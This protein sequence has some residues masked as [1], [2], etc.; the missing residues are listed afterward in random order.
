VPVIAREGPGG[1]Y[2]LPDNYRFEPLPLNGREAFLLLLAI[3]S[4]ESLSALPYHDELASLVVKLRAGLPAEEMAGAEGLLQA[5]DVSGPLRSQRAPFLEPILLAMHEKRWLRI[6]YRSSERVAVQ[7]ILPELVSTQDGLWYCRAFAAEHAGQRTFRVDRIQ[8]I[9]QPSEGFIPPPAVTGLPYEHESHP[10][11]LARLTSRGASRAE[12]E[13]SIGPKL[14]RLPDGSA[15]LGF[16]CPPDEIE[17]YA[18]FFAAL[19][20]DAEVL[21]PV[22]LRARLAQMGQKMVEM[23]T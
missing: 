19:G 7:H 16:R 20:E 15:E 6:T 21:A 13:R 23:Y 18:R 12:S 22:E 9:D 10:M 11:V 2:A 4:L 14:Q 5:V 1:G 8:G 17:Y 3:K